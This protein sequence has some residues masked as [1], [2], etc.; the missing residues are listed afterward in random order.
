MG[1]GSV[2]VEEEE[3]CLVHLHLHGGRRGRRQEDVGVGR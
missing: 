3:G 2:E 1:D